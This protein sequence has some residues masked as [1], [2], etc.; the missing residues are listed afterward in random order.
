LRDRDEPK[1][2]ISWF[3]RAVKLGDGDAN[4]Q[5]AKIHLRNQRDQRKAIDY[6]RKT[7]K[8]AY[9]TDGSIEEAKALLKQIR[10]KTPRRSE[11]VD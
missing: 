4:L 10:T 2:A 8:A 11:K 1:K 5:I 3:Q 7:I 9:V 6:L